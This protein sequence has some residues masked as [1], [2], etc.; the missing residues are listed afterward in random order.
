[1]GKIH[2]AS[3]FLTLS[4]VTRDVDANCVRENAIEYSL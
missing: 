3:I 1:M 4:S 2:F